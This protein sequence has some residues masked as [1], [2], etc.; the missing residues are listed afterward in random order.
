MTEENIQEEP[1]EETTLD[2]FLADI[3]NAKITVTPDLWEAMIT[4]ATE[5]LRANGSVSWE[6]WAVLGTTSRRAFAEAGDRLR[7]R[8][9]LTNE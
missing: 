5:F 1:K 9:A 4:E 2:W 6:R 8:A 7:I 3:S